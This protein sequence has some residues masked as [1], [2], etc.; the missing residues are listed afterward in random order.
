MEYASS[1]NRDKPLIHATT[2]MDLKSFMLREKKEARHESLYIVRFYLYDIL[3]KT[4]FC[5]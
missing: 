1:V 4:K 3:K 2:L 5:T